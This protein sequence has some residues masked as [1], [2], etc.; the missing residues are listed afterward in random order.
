MRAAIQVALQA[1]CLRLLGARRAAAAPTHRHSLPPAGIGYACAQ[2]LGRAG[3]KVLVADIDGA[4]AGEA[5]A[6]LRAE[7]IEAAST[8]CDVGSKEQVGA[9]P[10]GAALRQQLGGPIQSACALLISCMHVKAAAAAC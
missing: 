1:G 10:G 2:A 4:A 5:E 6:Q 7:G 3:A 9:G 8:A